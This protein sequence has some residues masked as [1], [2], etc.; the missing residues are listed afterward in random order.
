MKV[1]YIA[2]TSH[3]GSTLLDLMLNAHPEIVSLG[4]VMNLT[5]LPKAKKL[6]AFWS[7]VEQRLRETSGMSIMNLNVLDYTDTDARSAPNALLF[8]AVS[9]VTGKTFIVDSSK[10]P[11]RM[12][13]LMRVKRLDV[14]PV[15]LIR[16]PKG[17]VASAV[18]KHGGF[19]KHIVHYELVHQRIRRTLEGVAHSVVRY[20]DLVL[21]P[22]QTLGSL[23]E[24]LGL[25]F[26]PQQLSWAE[27]TKHLVAGN[28]MRRRKVSEL[29]L[30]EN[31]KDRLS[32]VQKLTIDIGTLRSR[33][34]HRQTGYAPGRDQRSST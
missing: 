20:E 33:L 12:S 29:I 16:N 11:E 9:H 22:E 28:R 3:S 8:G 4:E 30:D 32:F 18:K 27:Q 25:E 10:S 7:R 13:Y 1:I 17:Q 15:H 5:Q 14:Y 19:L 31:W 26:H 2:G 34:V 21:Q 24:P 6:S 23:L